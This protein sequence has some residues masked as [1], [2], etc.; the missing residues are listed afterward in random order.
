[1]TAGDPN[2][3]GRLR[4][5]P[6]VGASV[7]VAFLAV[8]MRGTVVALDDDLRGLEVQLSDGER[9]RFQLS[10]ATGTFLAADSSRARLLFE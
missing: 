7:Q 5:M 10:Q 1:M 8:R 2:P 3:S 9:V 4:A 6:R